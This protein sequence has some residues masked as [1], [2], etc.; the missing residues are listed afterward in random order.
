[1]KEEHPWQSARDKFDEE[2]I[3]WLTKNGLEIGSKARNGDEI[4]KKIVSTY[5]LLFRSFDPL[6]LIVLEKDIE[7][8]KKSPAHL[9]A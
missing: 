9:P 5:T 7:Q 2:I 3:P 6:N 1:M 4:C 8:Y